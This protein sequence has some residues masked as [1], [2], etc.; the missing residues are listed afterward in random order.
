MGGAT[1]NCRTQVN[2]DGTTTDQRFPN[3]VVSPAG[4]RLGIFY[5]SSQD[6]TANNNLFEHCGR[7]GGISG[8]T[9]RHGRVRA[10]SALATCLWPRRGSP[11]RAQL[12]AAKLNIG[13]ARTNSSCVAS[14]I[15]AADSWLCSH[16]IGSNVT[17]NSQAWK[18]IT[19]TYN[20]LTNYNEGLLCAPPR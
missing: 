3:V 14:A 8:A 11:R 18:Q 7:I 15:A 19:Q 2:G 13:C 10:A 17:A 9:A 16:L 4:D 6:D 1:L 12:A 5:Y 20:T